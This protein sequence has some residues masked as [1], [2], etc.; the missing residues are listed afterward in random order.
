M[1]IFDYIGFLKKSIHLHG[2]HSPFVFNLINKGLRSEKAI[3]K[4]LVKNKLACGISKKQ[5]KLLLKIIDYFNIRTIFVDDANL[6]K[7]LLACV[8]NSSVECQILPN[9]NASKYDLIFIKSMSEKE[10]ISRFLKCMYND[11]VLIVNDIHLKKNKKYWAELINHP[12]T[13]ACI[14]TFTQ[15]YVFI[16]KEQKKEVFFVKV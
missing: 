15:A 7:W 9:L 8:Q 13:T 6:Q 12:Q 11:S 10:N 5:R 4:A 3:S 2:V 14:N 16:R 1:I